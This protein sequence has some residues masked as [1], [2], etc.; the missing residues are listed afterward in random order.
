MIRFILIILE[1]LVDNWIK[2]GGATRKNRTSL[3]ALPMHCNQPVYYSGFYLNYNNIISLVKYNK[4]ILCFFF[5]QIVRYDIIVSMEIL[6]ILFQA[7]QWLVFLPF[8]IG[9]YLWIYIH[10][11]EFIYIPIYENYLHSDEPFI[12]LMLILPYPLIILIRWILFKEWIF[13]P[14]KKGTTK[15]D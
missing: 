3:Y 4:L 10:I 7:S 13:L 14:W 6:K 2:S 9:I 11:Y 1:V 15:E 12:T 8:L 5:C